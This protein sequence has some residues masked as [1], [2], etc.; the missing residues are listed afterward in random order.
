[1]KKLKYVLLILLITISI[2]V[3]VYAQDK[4]GTLT[5]VVGGADLDDADA[6]VKGEDAYYIRE[7][8]FYEML[9]TMAPYKERNINTVDAS[10][11]DIQKYT[12]NIARV[13]NKMISGDYAVYV[14]DYATYPYA[15]LSPIYLS[16]NE[17]YY[18][19]GIHN[20]IYGQVFVS[21]VE[22]GTDIDSSMFTPGGIDVYGKYHL[23]VADFPSKDAF[24]QEMR[25]KSIKDLKDYSLGN[26]PDSFVVISSAELENLA[27]ITPEIEDLSVENGINLC[28]FTYHTPW[29]TDLV[30]YEV[31]IGVGDE[32]IVS[33]IEPS[34]TN[35]ESERKPG[36]LGFILIPMFLIGT[37]VY[38][39][40]RQKMQKSQDYSDGIPITEQ[41]YVDDY[42]DLNVIDVDGNVIYEAPVNKE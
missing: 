3:P 11:E 40:I 16:T 17:E 27:E 1:M 6:Y 20:G 8:D 15:D 38:F 21:F 13:L 26:N 32:S 14:N 18:E 30:W 39:L 24:K 19:Y 34:Y 36:I 4:T 29:D 12:I 25:P 28:K 7:S 31:F 2:S 37:G 9:K 10:D 22:S 41:E 23:S 5:V 42:S 33:D 35:P